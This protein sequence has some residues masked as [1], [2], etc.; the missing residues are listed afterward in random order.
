MRIYIHPPPLWESVRKVEV[1]PVA[2]RT[3]A[4]SVAKTDLS[5]YKKS[6]YLLPLLLSLF[7]FLPFD[8]IA[9][10]V[11]RAAL[12]AASE[13]TSSEETLQV[14]QMVRFTLA[15]E[16][17]HERYV[18]SGREIT[19]AELI[20][21]AI[22]GMMSQLDPYS[23]L[24]ETEELRMFRETT[25]GEFGGIGVVISQRG[26]WV[27]VVSPIEGSPGWKADLQPGDRFV[28]IDGE[29]ARG[30]SVQDAVRQLRGEPGTEV[31]VR[32]AR[33]SENRMFSVSLVREVIETPSVEPHEVLE[34]GVGYLRVTLFADDTAQRIRRELTAM[35]RKEISSVILDLRGNPGGLLQAAV[36][37]TGLFLPPYSLVVYT[38]G[39]EEEQ[40]R[41]YRTSTRPHRLNPDLVVLVNGGSAS[42]AEIVSGALQDA[43]RATVVGTTTFGK[44][45]VQSMVPMPDGSALKLT[46]ATYYTP[47]GREIH[48]QGIV[49]DEEVSVSMGQWL[50][51]QSEEFT[52]EMDPQI[53]RA[54]E[55]V[56]DAPEEDDQ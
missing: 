41:E 34:D 48:Q 26:E 5:V 38:E 8:A 47:S 53:V 6:M 14:E 20:D 21:G 24:I 4:S 32:L 49:P 9:E 3:Y 36:E 28:E 44:A 40:R 19:Y 31:V 7:L 56:T 50:N 10:E 15:L 33:P 12:E 27:T 23:E 42:A 45:S 35:G 25:Q 17:I 2:A 37:V 1:K 29:S 51:R 46:T 30:Y 39:K 43:E 11:E 52:W 18:E 55:L 13:E 16:Q 54:V 22:S